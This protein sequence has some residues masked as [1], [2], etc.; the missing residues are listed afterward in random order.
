MADN[1]NNTD[2]TETLLPALEWLDVKENNKNRA[3]FNTYF[4]K[5]SG[6]EIVAILND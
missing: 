6:I 3:Y 5:V 4:G 2:K 1:D